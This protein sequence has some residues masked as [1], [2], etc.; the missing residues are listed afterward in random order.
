M[1]KVGFCISI[2]Y[3]QKKN[4]NPNHWFCPTLWILIVSIFT[5]IRFVFVFLNNNKKKIC[6]CIFSQE[7]NTI[8]IQIIDADL[9]IG[10]SIFLFLHQSYHQLLV[11]SITK[12]NVIKKLLIFKALKLK[13]KIKIFGP[14]YI[15][16]VHV[17]MKPT[18]FLLG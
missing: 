5:L 12:I 14:P 7:K 15:H 3:P 2:F 17:H 18:L 11:N 10:F 4:W 8:E 1:L 9:H 16:N 6:V 13:D